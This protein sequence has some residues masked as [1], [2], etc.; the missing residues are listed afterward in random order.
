MK[1]NSLCKLVKLK[2]SWPAITLSLIYTSFD[3]AV[4]KGL[5]KQIR[6][7]DKFL[8]LSKL[9]YL[10]CSKVLYFVVCNLKTDRTVRFLIQT[11]KVVPM[12]RDSHF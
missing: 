8:I 6:E 1:H 12:V 11:L 7:N 9:C 4:T 5:L 3:L 2:S 10:R